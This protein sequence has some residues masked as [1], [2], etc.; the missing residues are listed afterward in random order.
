[1][2]RIRRCL[3]DFA[4]SVKL[5][6]K[7]AVLT[8]AF[9]L[10]PLVFLVEL[11]FMEERREFIREQESLA[12]LALE[13][14]AATAR[15][16]A[17][18]C[19]AAAEAML[20]GITERELVES[21]AK[22]NPDIASARLFSGDD[23]MEERPWYSRPLPSDG[24]WKL[25]VEEDGE[26]YA[27]FLRMPELPAGSVL[28]LSARMDRLL[29]GMYEMEPQHWMGF[30]DSTGWLYYDRGRPDSEWRTVIGS[31]V[32]AAASVDR[33]RYT[34]LDLGRHTILVTSTYI[35]ELSGRVINAVMVESGLLRIAQ[36]HFA[37][38]AALALF[39]ALAYA[40]VGKA[41][42][43]LLRRFYMLMDV[44]REIQRGNLGV[45]VPDMGSDEIG[46]LASNFR[47]TVSRV[48]QL[49][50]TSVNRE[51]LVK[52]TEIRAL[53]NQINSH[54][55]YNVLE[56][57]KMMAEIEEKYEI[58]DA[59]TSLGELLRYSMRWAS[60]MVTVDEELEYIAAYISLLNL[61]YDFTITLSVDLMPELFKQKIPKMSLQP[62]V[63]NAVYHGIGDMDADACIRIKSVV[64]SGYYEIE[65]SD[66]GKGM[67][68]EQLALLHK[69]VY[70]LVK[71]EAKPR[72]GIGLRN[73]QERLVLCFGPGCGLRFVSKVGCFTKVIVTL[74][75]EETVGEIDK[76]GE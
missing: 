72:G 2:K 59:V 1:M 69:Q 58:S 7:L 47:E 29:P 19:E 48:D 50:E 52:T 8:I 64:L 6:T 51:L 63:E 76:R 5:S 39:T 61:R 53:Q 3:Y 26:E 44:G 55:I 30:V 71:Q 73:V 41:V 22:G 45:T 25:G 9:V 46:E 4:L 13:N 65:I 66:T 32:Y 10:A 14:S 42:N 12:L 35:P 36:L 38:L 57:I 16:V 40:A 49:L 15:G 27:L 68:E 74:P 24:T 17:A 54:F 21:V 28:E 20:T 75:L 60:S 34:M 56:S 23:R 31:V 70:G 18:S 37:A 33:E 62:I 43:M 11:F 67:D